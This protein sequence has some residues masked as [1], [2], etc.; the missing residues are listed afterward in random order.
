MSDTS[1][2]LFFALWPSPELQH[3]LHALAWQLQPQAHGPALRVMQRENLHLTLL[4]L[5]NVPTARLAELI[6]MA[7]DIRLPPFTLAL[8]KLGYF[9]EAKV[10][11]AGIRQPPPTL[12]DLAMAL[13]RGC[14]ALGL[15]LDPRPL[16][17]HVTLL[18]KVQAPP[19]LTV[20]PPLHWAVDDFAL[21]V[22]VGGSYR[23]LR[24][25]G[26]TKTDVQKSEVSA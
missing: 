25:F 19:P 7:A 22:S 9:P 26:F 15:P 16:S 4:F 24:R 12:F 13:R 1:Q 14:T 6:D 5:G 20:I 2:R 21:V 3:H 17:P 11:W 18:R 8:D 23:V 10:A